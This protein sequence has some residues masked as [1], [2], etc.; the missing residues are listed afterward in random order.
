M[1]ILFDQGTPVPLR[2]ELLGHE[3]STAF[4]LGWSELTNGDLLR[5]AEEAFDVLI[6]TDQGLR[7]QQNLAG[8]KL[9]II[10]LQTTSWPLIQRQVD[11]I[12]DA[13]TRVSPGGFLGVSFSP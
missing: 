13:L 10:V 11:R 8:R 6:S 9:S 2:R 3:I 4:E 1:K 7:F 12:I 5:A